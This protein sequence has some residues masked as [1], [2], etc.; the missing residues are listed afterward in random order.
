LTE[1]I[2]SDKFVTVIQ[3][4]TREI[5]LAKSKNVFWSFFSS[6]KLTVV[7]LTLMV[8]LFIVATLLPAPRNT[9]EITWLNDLYRSPLFYV[10]AALFSLNLIICSLN[11][12]PVAVRQFR[13][14]R[15]PPPPGI[16]YNLEKKSIVLSHKDMTAGEAIVK[17]VLSA[18]FASL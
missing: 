8:L 15:F 11:R 10:M 5:F 17:K 7:L 16:F 13:A 14:P 9:Q 12:L 4:R 3:Q 6:V 2:I 1:K 18:N